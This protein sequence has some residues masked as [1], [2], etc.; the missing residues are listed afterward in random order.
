MARP[1]RLITGKFFSYTS[2]GPDA[3]GEPDEPPMVGLIVQFTPQVPITLEKSPKR[4]AFMQPIFGVTNEYGDLKAPD[5]ILG[6]R[7]PVST[8]E[9]FSYSVRIIPPDGSQAMPYTF[10]TLVTPGSDP[11]DMS[12]I[13]MIQSPTSSPGLVR[14]QLED[15]RI[16][17]SNFVGWW[18]HSAVADPDDGVSTGSGILY[19][20]Y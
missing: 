2:D 16:A 15:P 12:D 13:P 5:G 17:D 6:F 7:V 1:T 11:W 9:N 4:V 19:Y 18:L 8:P 3:L 20:I 14:V 10:Y